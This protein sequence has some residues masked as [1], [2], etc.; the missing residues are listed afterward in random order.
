MNNLNGW[1]VGGILGL[2]LGFIISPMVFQ[3]DRMIN[4]SKQ[5]MNNIDRYFIE[6]MIPHHEGAIEMAELALQKA[7]QPE[8]KS[9]ANGIIEAQQKEITDMKGWYKQWFG[10][11]VPVVGQHM[12]NGQMMSGMNH[13][14]SMSGDM[15]TLKNAKD[16]DFEFVQQMIP[17]HEMAVMMAQMLQGSTD[18]TEMKILADNI[19]TSQRREIDMMRLWVKE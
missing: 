1:I 19:I 2:I 15:E 8:V 5:M 6:Q 7:K 14:D 18:Q 9:L 17:H 10:I 4:D 12:M 13:M 11:D 16:F 3:S